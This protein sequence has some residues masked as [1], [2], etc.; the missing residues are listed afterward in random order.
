MDDELMPGQWLPAGAHRRKVDKE[1]ALLSRSNQPTPK[2]AAR[3]GLF[4]EPSPQQ[5]PSRKPRF[6]KPFGP[7]I[8]E[9]LEKPFRSYGVKSASRFL[10][11]N[12]RSVCLKKP[13]PG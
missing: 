8:T 10:S 4:P 5:L 3:L 1:T 2:V 12:E 13:C 11:A 9:N 6:H 7:I